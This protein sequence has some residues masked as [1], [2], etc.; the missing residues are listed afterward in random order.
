M[1]E[2]WKNIQGYEGLY[3]VSNMGRVKSLARRLANGQWKDE[4]F[5]VPVK[6]KN[7]YYQVTLFDGFNKRYKI[8]LLHR[9]I[10]TAFI[11]N[12]NNYP[13]IDH[14]DGN[15]SNNGLSNLRWVTH[16]MNSNNP[17]CLDRRSKQLKIAQNRPEIMEKK[18]RSAKKKAVFQYSMYGEF[19]KQW[20]S[21]REA[22][23]ELGLECTNISACA[24]GRK[25]SAYGYLWSRTLRDDIKYEKVTSA[26]AVL[27]YDLNMNL[28]NEY[29]CARDAADATG[30]LFSCISSCCV[31]R[32]K[33]SKGFIWKFKEN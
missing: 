12:P 3:Q 17:I 14:I 10:A 23:R 20:S 30:C 4:T 19:I 18:I 22:C 16:K 32:F 33:S 24:S 7:G 2:V 5:K 25:K 27:Q 9:A 13:C 11:P 29:R 6:K 21:V 15:P 1:E 28:L 8:M 26:K 31:G